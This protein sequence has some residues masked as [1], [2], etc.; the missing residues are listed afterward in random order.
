MISQALQAG[1]HVDAQ[2]IHSSE[3]LKWFHRASDVGDD[4]VRTS[5]GKAVRAPQILNQLLSSIR[6]LGSRMD[7]YRTIIQEFSGRRERAKRQDDR[8]IRG[9]NEGNTMLHFRAVA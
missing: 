2:F 5:A 1:S 8:T 7:G 3:V 9:L 6:N 4:L